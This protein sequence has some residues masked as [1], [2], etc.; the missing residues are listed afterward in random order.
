MHYLTC[1]GN[2]AFLMSGLAAGTEGI[3]T[4]EHARL[5]VDFR[6]RSLMRSR[7]A[8]PCKSE[9]HRARSAFSDYPHITLK[10]CSPKLIESIPI[11]AV[12]E[13]RSACR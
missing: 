5:L 12:D 6:R 1:M 10:K 4:G 2:Q 13:R 3:V 7:S 9:R 8:T 11:E